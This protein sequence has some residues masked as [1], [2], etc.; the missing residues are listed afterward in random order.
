MDA[1]TESRHY[2]LPISWDQMQT[3]AAVLADQLAQHGRWHG[4]VAVAR[5][6][7][8]PA[9]LVSRALGIRRLETVSAVT[10]E[11]VH[12]SEPELLKFPTAAGDGA[13]WLVIDD[14]VDT[15]TTMRI[16]RGILPRAHVGVLYAKPVGRPLA[17]TFV[18][19]FPQDSWI[20]FPWEMAAAFGT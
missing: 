10:Y 20:D 8:V 12:Q 18:R 3:D 7:L 16:I 6:G 19:E 5:G 15:G 9:A 2:H 14:L 13:G 11:G 17:H 4:I 1:H